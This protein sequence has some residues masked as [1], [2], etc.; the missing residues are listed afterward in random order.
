MDRKRSLR[1]PSGRQGGPGSNSGANPSTSDEDEPEQ[2][3]APAPMPPRGTRRAARVDFSKL[4]TNSLRKYRKF[5]HIADIPSNSTKEELIPVVARHFASQM[6][7]ED[8]ALLNFALALKK[9]NLTAKP[10]KPANKSRHGS[11]PKAR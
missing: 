7:D 11:K 5:Y 1:A 4:E 8:E 2:D 10:A 9:H 6:V 3:T